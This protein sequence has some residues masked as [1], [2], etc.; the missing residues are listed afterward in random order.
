MSVKLPQIASKSEDGFVDLSFA[1]GSRQQKA[2]C[3]ERLVAMGRDGAQDVGF[4]ILL[5]PGWKEVRLEGVKLTTYQGR[6]VVESIGQRSNS[7]VQAI[8]RLYSTNAGVKEMGQAIRFTGI[9]LGGNPSDLDAGPAKIKLFFEGATEGRYAEIYVN[10]DVKVGSV[11][12]NEKDP[13]YRVSVVHALSG[14]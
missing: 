6:A 11:E 1:I 8:D 7:L 3:G 13:D 4:A 9:S 10:I 14:N 12:L 2:A 5:E